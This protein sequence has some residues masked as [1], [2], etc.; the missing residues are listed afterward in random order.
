MNI[1]IVG[2][3][4]QGTLLTSKVLGE[5]ARIEGLD[6][7][8]SEVHGMSQRGGSVVTH[9]RMGK[10]V[11]SPIIW[12]GGA[13]VV[14]AFEELEGLRYSHYLTK[15]GTLL[16]NDMKIYPMP[17]IMGNVEY[18]K[19]IKEKLLSLGINAHF[20]KAYELSLQAGSGKCVNIVMLGAL[21]AVLGLDKEAMECA[22]AK[23]V[24]EKYKEMNLKAL[25]LGYSMSCK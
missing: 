5:Y 14:L 19:D 4:G 23:C 10:E 12:E 6:V 7:K 13:D 24:P 2:V 15:E 11:H 25:E 22:V 16:I 17:V 21:V 1:L 3:G 9:V 20:I 18:P 8:L